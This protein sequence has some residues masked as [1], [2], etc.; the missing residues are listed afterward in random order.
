MLSVTYVPMVSSHF[1]YYFGAASKVCCGSR[2]FPLRPGEAP[3]F[4]TS[5]NGRIRSKAETDDLGHDVK[6]MSKQL[7]LSVGRRRDGR[8]A[9]FPKKQSKEVIAFSRLLRSYD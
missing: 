1:G 6:I 3:Q 7:K 4:G 8:F 2:R 5:P 9:N